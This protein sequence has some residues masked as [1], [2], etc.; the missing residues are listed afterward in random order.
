VLYVAALSVEQGGLLAASEPA[1]R[2]VHELRDVADSLKRLSWTGIL[3]V[4]RESPCRRW[5][6][7]WGERAV[8]SPAGRRREA[9]LGAPRARRGDPDTQLEAPWP[10]ALS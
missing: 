6:V 7:S 3:T 1:N 9:A 4:K 8:G 2:G 10:P 5:R